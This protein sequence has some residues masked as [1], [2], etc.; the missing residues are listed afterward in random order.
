MGRQGQ[1][2]PRDVERRLGGRHR[3][4]APAARTGEPER[5]QRADLAEEGDRHV[6]GR[7]SRAPQ[8]RGRRQPGGLPVA[9]RAEHQLQE[10]RD[11]AGDLQRLPVLRPRRAGAAVPVRLRPVV[12]DLRVLQARRRA[13]RR[14][15]G[16]RV[17]RPQHRHAR[18]RR[19]RAGLPRARP[20]GRRRAAGAPRPRR[21]PTRHPRTGAI[22][23]RDRPRRR[24][25]PAVLG[26]GR[27]ALADERRPATDLGGRRRLRRAPAAHRDDRRRAADLPEPPDG[28]AAPARAARPPPAQRDGARQRQARARAPRR[29]APSDAALRRPPEGH[30]PR[31]PRPARPLGRT[32]RRPPDLSPLHQAATLTPG[33]PMKRIRHVLVLAVAAVLLAAPTAHAADCPWMQAG[34]TPEQRADELIHAMTLDQKIHQVTFSTPQWFAYY[35]TAG[36][37]DGTPALC[38]PTLVLSD[39]GSGVAGL[40]QGTTTFPSG[41]AQAAMW[42]P[43]LERRFGEAM[44]QE[45]W[46]KGINVMLGPGLNIA[47]IATN[48]RNFEYMGE[49]PFLTGKTAAAA[50]RGIQSQNVLAQAKPYAANNRETA[51]MPFAPPV[52]GRTP[53][54]TTLPGWEPATKEGPSAATMGPYNRLNGPYACEN[55]ELLD[56]Y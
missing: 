48:G 53:P 12:H 5:P 8:R 50:I 26:R 2:H 30:R 28:D 44:G 10:D 18:R 15:A 14:R 43:A 56:G 22:A 23:T 46:N 40:Q 16:R 20:G 33:D 29:R 3:D 49:D 27:P 6:V 9:D 55:K 4:R 25:R 42:D 52:D 51:R 31:P 7:P 24:A 41:V 45:A 21:L 34:K 54:E 38:I 39:A 19:G 47:R 11:D 35:G 1:G 17:H 37:I 13:A 32:R 36:H